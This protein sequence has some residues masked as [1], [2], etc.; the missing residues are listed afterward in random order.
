MKR[1]NEAELEA[2]QIPGEKGLAKAFDIVSGVPTMGV[3]IVEPESN[4]PRTPHR[5]PERQV[6]Y[7]ISGTATISNDVE[8]IDLIPGDFVL[9][10]SNEEHYV[11]TGK[12]EAKVFEVK[13]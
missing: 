10:E 1:T 12:E 13:Y 5:H 7:M 8:T 3:R 11:S 9:L 4:V 6:I 2:F